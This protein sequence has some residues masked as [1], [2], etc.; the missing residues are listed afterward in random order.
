MLKTIAGL[1]P[2]AIVLSGVGIAIWW[3]LAR[4]LA[5]GRWVLGGFL[6]A[7]GLIHFLFVVPAPATTAG[8]AEWP[9][10]MTQSWL[11]TGAGLD[12]GP[13]RV[14]G[15]ALIGIVAIGFLLAGLATVGIVI[16]SGWWRVLVVGSAA[17]SI[18]LLALFFSPQLV[19]GLG[20]DAV[21]LLIA[22]AAVWAPTAAVAG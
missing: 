16:P 19:L 4:D 15:A 8:G 13:V 2:L 11:V 1:A 6:V 18:V 20:I 21:L 3:L 22:V 10:D 12:M 9:F 17:A 7:H 5:I 14:I